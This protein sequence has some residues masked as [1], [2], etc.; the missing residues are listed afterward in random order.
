METQALPA[1]TLTAAFVAISVLALVVALRS[2]SGGKVEVRLADA[3]IDVIP[4][5]LWLFISGQIAKFSVGTGG[6]EVEATKEAILTASAKPIGG[7]VSALPVAPVEMALKGSVDAIPDLVRREV[8][9]IHLVL[10]FAGYEAQAL[11][12]YLTTLARYPFFRYVIFSNP[13]QSLFGVIDGRKLAAILESRTVGLSWPDFAAMLNRGGPAERERLS[14]IPGF[15]P[16]ANA[17]GRNTDKRQ[18]LERMEK[19]GVEWL[20]VVR[21][22]QR[23]EGVVDRSR[24]TASLILDVS[25][26]LSAAK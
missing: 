14:R 3:A 4:I 6:I 15:I 18:V 16:S 26:Q 25:A 17:V 22:D 2:I 1:G 21:D 9:A 13:D 20:P 24:L 12:Q 8:Q 23:F 5:V 11:D 10:G 7:Q 19:L